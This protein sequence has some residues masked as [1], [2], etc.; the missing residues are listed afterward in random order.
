[1]L[2]LLAKIFFGN[3]IEQLTEVL[4]SSCRGAQRGHSRVLDNPGVLHRMHPHRMTTGLSERRESRCS[5][6]RRSRCT[7]HSAGPARCERWCD[8]HRGGFAGIGGRAD[9][10]QACGRVPPC[11]NH[12][13]ENLGGDDWRERQSAT[14]GRG[15]DVPPVSSGWRAGSATDDRAARGRPGGDP[16]FGLRIPGFS[17]PHVGPRGGG[18]GKI[19]RSVLLV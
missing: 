13:L 14:F 6:D 12:Q 9:G 17:G 2:A 10:G 16:T 4:R 18:A 19:Q 3:G 11:A 15:L 1:M 8:V 7:R 5:P